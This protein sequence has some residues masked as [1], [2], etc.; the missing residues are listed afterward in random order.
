[1]KDELTTEG[2]KLPRCFAGSDSEIFRNP[3][4]AGNDVGQLV[5]S[6]SFDN[7]VILFSERLMHTPLLALGQKSWQKFNF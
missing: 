7:T 5:L 2:D 4:S 6:A 3:I 1:M